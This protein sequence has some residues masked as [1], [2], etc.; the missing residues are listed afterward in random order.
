MNQY[1]TGGMI[2]KL[3]ERKNL[4][5]SQ[6]AERIGVSDKTV[7]KWETGCGAFCAPFA[8]V[9]KQADFL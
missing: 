6:L 5:Q 8:P 4:T 9:G 2:R 7:S 3:R 1:V